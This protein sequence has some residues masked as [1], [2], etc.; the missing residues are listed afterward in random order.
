MLQCF[1]KG[2]AAALNVKMST[3]ERRIEMLFMLM[4]RKYIPLEELVDC[5]QVHKNTICKDISFLSRYAPLYTKRGVAGG[6]FMLAEYSNK[7]FLYLSKDEE[8]VLLDVMKNVNANQK[9]L[10]QGIINR[11]SMPK[12]SV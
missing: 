6:V 7:L 12:R 1:T 10:L 3:F 11:Y 4:N 5:F 9:L 8:E 2:G